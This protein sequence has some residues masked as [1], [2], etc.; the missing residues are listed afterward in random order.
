MS[1]HIRM[2]GRPYIQVYR[3]RQQGH[4]FRSRLCATG[5]R[6]GIATFPP[7]TLRIGISGRACQKNL[8]FLTWQI[9]SRQ[10]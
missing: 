9:I 6:S 4:I 8:L 10:I 2:M 3:S 1:L 5:T 7:Q